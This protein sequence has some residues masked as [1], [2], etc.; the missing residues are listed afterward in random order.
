MVYYARKV[1]FMKLISSGFVKQPSNPSTNSK[2]FGCIT[3]LPSGRWLCGYKASPLK[4]DEVNQYALCTYSDDEGQTWSDPFEPFSIRFFEERPVVVRT[5]YFTSLGDSHVLAVCNIVDAQ[6]PEKPYF[7]PV[8]E[9]LKDTRILAAISQDNGISYSH[10][11]LIPTRGID[12]PTPLTGAPFWYLD[13]LHIPFEVNKPYEAAGEWI[14]RSCFVTLQI[15][16]QSVSDPVCLTGVSGI[17]YWDQRFTVM[18]HNLLD[19]FWTYDARLKSYRNVHGLMMKDNQI[20]DLFDC[21]FPGQPGY[22]CSVHDRLYLPV[23]DRTGSPKIILYQSVDGQS[24]SPAVTVYDSQLTSQT[25]ESVD[26]DGAWSEMALFSV[27]HPQSVRL[28]NDDILVYYYAGQKTDETEICF[29]RY[30]V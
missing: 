21:G 17:F 25:A 22:G 12:A 7:R 28:S 20:S 16:D 30:R 15:S 19:Y 11:F 4:S 9:G 2:T 5:V 13:Q 27:G 18:D 10:P 23:I 29:A 3:V 6:H 24:F 14:H 8:H 26:M 1:T